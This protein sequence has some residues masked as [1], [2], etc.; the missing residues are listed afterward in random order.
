MRFIDTCSLLNLSEKAFEEPF[1][2]SFITIQELENIKVSQ[3][4]DAECKYKSRAVTRLLDA[5]MD[6]FT[7]CFDG[8][9][10]CIKQGIDLTND[11]I[12]LQGAI[13][14]NKTSPTIFITDDLLLKIKGKN[15]RL[16]VMS[17]ADILGNEICYKGYKLISGNTEY[18][19]D[20]MTEID[21]SKWSVNEYIVLQNTDDKK[22]TE[23]R[24]DGKEFV[25]LKY[26]KSNFIKAKNS[27][28]RCALD[29][30]MNK[31]ITVVAV[32]GGFG[33][34]KSFLTTKM[35][36]YNVVEKGQ[37]S[38]I[39]CVREPKG[40]GAGCGFLPGN[41]REKTE[42]FFKPIEQQLGGGEFELNTLLSSG[43]IETNIPYYL[44]GTTFNDTVI[45]VEEAED[46]TESQIRLIGSRVGTNGKVYFSGDYEQSLLNK[47]RDNA[48]IKMCNEFK[49]DPM[50]GC[51][52]LGEDVRSETSKMFTTLYK[53]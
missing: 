46:L 3:N 9:E 53:H 4:K 33:S 32:L 28:Q 24:F 37:Q 44:K 11:N 52:Y 47:T 18:L 19:N 14:T 43:V 45:V 49:G 22:T 20:Y 17:S 40:E 42:Y 27:L 23:M 25:I 50:F 13:L 7:V 8:K 51:I 15:A 16:T 41:M 12:I 26:P 5:N 36:I 30:L 21:L 6:K 38:K 29:L 48:L 31:D 10:E 35:A 39:L 2:I 34:G 1:I